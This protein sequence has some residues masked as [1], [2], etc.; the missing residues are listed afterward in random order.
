VVNIAGKKLGEYMH[1]LEK[2]FP[3]GVNELE[4]AGLEQMNSNKV[5]PPRV[6]DAIA[7][8][9]CRTVKTVELGDHIWITGEVLECEVKDQLYDKVIKA[10]EEL[11]HISGKY[12]AQ[13]SKIREYKRA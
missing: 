3:Y 4:E 9:E 2:D 5:K 10:G 8:L 7:W 1:I 13:D 12:F 11:C 6:K